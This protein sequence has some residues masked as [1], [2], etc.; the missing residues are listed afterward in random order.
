VTNGGHKTVDHQ[1]DKMLFDE[2][3]HALDVCDFS[4]DEKKVCVTYDASFVFSLQPY[5]YVYMST[6]FKYLIC[7]FNTRLNDYRTLRLTVDWKPLEM[8]LPS[9]ESKVKK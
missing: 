3:Q 2:L 8:L 5:L 4:P 7:Y 9:D 1:A 6:I